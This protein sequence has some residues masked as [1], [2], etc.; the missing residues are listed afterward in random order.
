MG[1]KEEKIKLYLRRNKEKLEE[2]ESGLVLYETY[3]YGGRKIKQLE[4]SN[5]DL[6]CFNKNDKANV[7]VEIKT[8]TA[9]YHTFGQILYYLDYVKDFKCPNAKLD[10]QIVKK[11]RGIILAKRIDKPLEVL[12]NKYKSYIPEISLKIYTEDGDGNPILM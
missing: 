6:L 7:V 1:E 5:I 10:E 9:T 2:L 12:I 8:G 3:C 4:P 11:V